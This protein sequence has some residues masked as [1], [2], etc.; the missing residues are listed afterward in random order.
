MHL[1]IFSSVITGKTP[2]DVARKTREY[3]LHSVQFVPDEVN[4][5]WGFDGNGAQGPFDVWAEAYANEGIE[6]CAV[7]GYINLLP[8]NLAEREKS[9]EVFSSF[10]RRMKILGTR[11][12]STETGSLSPKGAWTPDP[13]NQ[14]PEAWAVFRRIT[15]ILVRVAEEEDVVILYEP[16][17]ANVTETPERGVQLV[18]EVNSPH[19]RMM[20]DPTN[21]F[22]ADIARPDLVDAT[23]LRGFAAEHGL[24]D[25]AHAKDVLPAKPGEELPGLP[26]PGKGMLNYPLYLDLLIKDGYDGP[27]IMEHLTEE[28]IPESIEF[29][30]KQ[31]DAAKARAAVPVR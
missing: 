28:Q 8:R 19:L 27:L 24:Y 6:I 26:G 22:S 23:I 2:A 15:D 31:I 17:V 10:L 21:W 14:T 7:A 1:S 29:V 18:R 4:V 16:Y 9:I 30:Q 25:L 20:M 3:G 5:G 11:Y 13:A 12:I